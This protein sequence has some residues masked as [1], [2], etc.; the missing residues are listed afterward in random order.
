LRR[1][2]FWPARDGSFLSREESFAEGGAVQLVFFDYC[3]R[4]L[5]HSERALINAPA[6]DTV[7]FLERSMKMDG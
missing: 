6:N 1:R 3:G 7:F 2:E 5:G 4:R